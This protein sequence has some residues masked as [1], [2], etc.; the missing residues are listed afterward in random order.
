MRLSLEES[1]MK[2]REPTKP[3]Q[4]IG[5]VG[6]PAIVAGIEPKRV[7]STLNLLAASEFNSG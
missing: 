7:H 3:T 2:F 6:H 1:R 5:D 4:E